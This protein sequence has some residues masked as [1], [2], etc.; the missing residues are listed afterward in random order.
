MAYSVSL[1]GWQRQE[2]TRV[3]FCEMTQ[4]EIRAYIATKEP[5]DKAGAYGIQGAF[6]SWVS[7]IDGCYF[8]VVGL[9]V[10]KLSNLF[11]RCVGCYPKDIKG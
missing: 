6:S 1:N 3:H 8:G 2:K 4:E 11:Y 7:G 5:M 9:P 10:N